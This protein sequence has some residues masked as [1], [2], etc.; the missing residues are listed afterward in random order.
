MEQTAGF[1]AAAVVAQTLAAVA[2]IQSAVQSVV[3]VV[4]IVAELELG[5]VVLVGLVAFGP[6]AHVVGKLVQQLE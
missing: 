3:A 1:V 4:Y 5:L 2:Y 6:V